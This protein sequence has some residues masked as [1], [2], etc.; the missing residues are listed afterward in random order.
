MRSGWTDEPLAAAGDPGADPGGLLLL[1]C[2]N[3]AEVGPVVWYKPERSHT[4]LILP[5]GDD[6]DGVSSRNSS[7]DNPKS[8][9]YR[10]M[11]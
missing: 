5:L 7:P 11:L 1:S 6:V 3:G 2:K 8:K 4:I 10:V 9:K